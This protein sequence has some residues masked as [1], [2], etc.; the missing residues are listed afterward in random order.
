MEFRG[1]GI[2]KIGGLRTRNF[3]S[4]EKSREIYTKRV[5]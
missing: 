3:G 2:G 5:D 4:N 1:Y